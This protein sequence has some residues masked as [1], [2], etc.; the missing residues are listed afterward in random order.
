MSVIECEN[1]RENVNISCSA[2]QRKHEYINKLKSVGTRNTVFN[3]RCPVLCYIG[4][5]TINSFSQLFISFDTNKFESIFF[6]LCLVVSH[7][8]ADSFGFFGSNIFLA[9]TAYTEHRTHSKF[10][11]EN[12]FHREKDGKCKKNLRFYAL[13]FVVR[14]DKAMVDSIHSVPGALA[15]FFVFVF[16]F[17]ILLHFANK[18]NGFFS[19]LLLTAHTKCTLHTI[20][21]YFFI[22]FHILFFSSLFL[23]SFLWLRL[24]V[25]ANDGAFDLSAVVHSIAFISGLTSTNEKYRKNAHFVEWD[26]MRCISL[27]CNNQMKGF[28]LSL[29]HF[30]FYFSIFFISYNWN[31]TKAFISLTS[32]CF[33]SSFSSFFIH[34]SFC[35]YHHHFIF[36]HNSPNET[37]LHS[38]WND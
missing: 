8:L 37:M 10:K 20:F 2:Q 31:A 12:I 22:S 32:I 13:P 21:R 18:S 25:G 36:I 6:P 23:C 24:L 17:S 1:I 34:C 26:E 7:N 33:F 5:Y 11:M 4:F 16:I 27:Q 28:S 29:S 30:I 15:L 9:R 19:A 3:I 35:Y 14:L 38:K